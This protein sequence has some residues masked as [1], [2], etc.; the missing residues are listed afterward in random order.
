MRT[1]RAPRVLHHRAPVP[2][3]AVSPAI[4]GARAPARP[5]SRTSPGPPSPPC[6]VKGAAGAVEMER[7]VIAAAIAPAAEYDREGERKP[8]PRPRIVVA[9]RRRSGLGEGRRFDRDEAEE[10]GRRRVEG[11][12]CAPFPGQRRS[13]GRTALPPPPG[14]SG[15]SAPTGSPQ[16]LQTRI[17]DT[18]CS[19]VF[20]GQAGRA[21]AIRDTRSGA[22]RGR[23]RR[24]SSG[25]TP[26]AGVLEGRVQ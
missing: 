18:G 15:S 23:C 6:H 22:A 25:A 9:G 20:A 8:P 21:G 19:G 5:P 17:V 7:R 14:A 13:T 26:S 10:G 2:G 12:A 1:W 24:A 4:S 11:T 3:A 16:A